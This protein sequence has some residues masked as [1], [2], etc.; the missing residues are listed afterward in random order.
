MSNYRQGS[1]ES[2]YSASLPAIG[3]GT[4]MSD[5]F[6]LASPQLMSAGVPVPGFAA[7]ASKWQLFDPFDQSQLAAAVDTRRQ[8]ARLEIQG[9]KSVAG[10]YQQLPVPANVPGE[11]V[12]LAIYARLLIAGASATPETAALAPAIAGLMIGEDLLGLGAS[13]QL[14]LWG[15]L[16]ARAPIAPPTTGDYT[17]G[18]Y[19][20]DFIQYDA[21]LN[22]L[23]G[24]KFF[25]PTYYRLRVRQECL[26]LNTFQCSVRFDCGLDGADFNQV[27]VSTFPEV[28]LSAGVGLYAPANT[29]VAC[30]VDFFQIVSQSYDD[31]ASYIGASAQL[32]AV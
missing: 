20:A 22:P 11:I 18:A 17:I 28:W 8:A 23:G 24:V 3:E 32:G 27:W 31:Q 1:Y 26:A 4:A 6:N 10:I 2:P 5:S 16:L 12:D 29:S 15:P 25:L 30:L 13:S 21:I 19:L 9:A 14:Q 7:L